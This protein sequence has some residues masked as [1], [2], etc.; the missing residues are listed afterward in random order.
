MTTGKTLPPLTQDTLDA[1]LALAYQQHQSGHLTEAI[2]VY[3]ST[4][5][6]APD[7]P[8]ALRYL[9]LARFQTGQRIEAI[10]L[11]NRAAELAPDAPVFSDLGRMYALLNELARAIECFRKAVAL[12]SNYADGWHNLGTALRQ[13]GDSPGALHAYRQALVLNPKRGDTYLNLGNLLVDD[14]QPENAIESFKRAAELDPRLPQARTS[15]AGELSGRGNVSE[16]EQV[17]RQALVLDPR[18]VQAWFGL[19]RTLEDLGKARE[20]EHCYRQVLALHPGQAWALGQLLGLEGARVDESL[21][22]H[23]QGMLYAESTPDGAKALIGYGLGKVHDRRGNYDTAFAAFQAANSARRKSAGKFDETEFDQRINSI[24]ETFTPEFFAERR[25]WGIGNNLPVF[26]VGM[27]RS[28][29]TLT[30]QILHSHPLMFGAGELPHLADLAVAMPER[31]G[32][33]TSWPVCA[34]ELCTE[35]VHEAAH[36]YLTKLH[37]KTPDSALRA[38]DKAP[39]NFYHLGLVVLLFPNAHIVH[40]RRNPLDTCLSIYFENFRPN[41][42]YATD[43]ADLVVYYRGYQKLMAHWRQVLPLPMLEFDY[44]TSVSDTEMQTRALLRFLGVPWDDACLKFH[45]ARRAVQTPSRWQVRKPIY[46]SSIERWRRY[47]KHVQ[48]LIDAFA[49]TP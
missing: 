30:E 2:G 18:H 8:R 15:L 37:E 47:E 32:L 20:A 40:C 1:Q 10:R 3:E 17:Y 9:G 48:V 45:E 14:N 7:H 22:A 23:A 4:L 39:L 31:F 19:G 41:Q 38:S 36:A 44:E 27:P 42:T 13:S 28:G 16:A 26:I 6:H 21:L 12:D 5:G 24:I 34:G 35:H 25:A 43:L 49:D 33:S 46:S 11:L 29:T